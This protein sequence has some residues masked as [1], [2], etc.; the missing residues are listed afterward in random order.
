MQENLEGLEKYFQC[1]LKDQFRSM[2]ISYR[3]LVEIV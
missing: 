3:R 2:K 1:L